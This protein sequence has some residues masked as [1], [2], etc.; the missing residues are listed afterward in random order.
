MWYK[1]L[2]TLEALK[3]RVG[4]FPKAPGVYLMKGPSGRVLYV[5]KAA[6]LRS[7]VSNYFSKEAD[8][9]YQVRFLMAKVHSIDTI[10]TDNEKEALLLENT[11]IK[12]FRPRYNI[13]LKDDRS[14]VSLKLSIQHEAPR[15]Y[16][17]R[18]IQKD[19]SLL[20]GPYTSAGACREVVD[21]IETHFRLRTCSDHDYRNRVRPCLQ[22]QIKRCDAPCVGLIS[23][24]D[25]RA[26]VEQVRLF[27]EGKSQKLKQVAQEEMRKAAEREN[28]E[29]AARYRDLLQDIKETLEKQKVV[30]HSSASRDIL[31]FIREGEHMVIALMAFREGALQGSTPFFLRGLQED[32][33]VIASFLTQFYREG[34]AFPKEILLP[35]PLKDQKLLEEILRERGAKGLRLVCPQKGEKAA[36]LKLA[37]QNARQ[38]FV[39]RSAQDRDREA[40]LQALQERFGLHRRPRRLECYDISHFQGGEAVGSMVTFLEGRPAKKLYRT[41][42]IKTATG[43]DDF[44][45]L[46][47]VLV[48][49]LGRGLS[50]GEDEG[51][52]WALPDLMVI[53]GGKAQLHAAMQAIKDTGTESISVMALAKS[54]L[55]PTEGIPTDWQKRTRSEERVF[56]PGRKNPVMLHQNS[57][58]RYL[59]TQARDEAHRFGIES[60]RKARQ[61]R[62]LQSGLD[63][64]EGVGKIRRQKLLKKFGSLK[65]IKEAELGELEKTLGGT[66]ALAQRVKESL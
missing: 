16:V 3:K 11:L 57:S 7:R 62:G 28:F 37:R 1:I 42:K 32:D 4:H 55:Q 38:A 54:R 66:R 17:T 52:P 14:Y 23:L 41:F 8:G 48:R 49:R 13:E 2:V 51:D 44:A 5:G 40:I 58:E 43:G 39:M 61:R 45:S 47:E 26:M 50:A 46:Y 12:K 63:R 21:F 25:Y 60:H 30:R 29:E 6:N 65:A 31:G 9:R 22:Y 59:L 27:L 20:F 64:I 10:V 15:L 18:R 36:W 33:E 56:L 24:T 19:G 35:F 34:R 53:D